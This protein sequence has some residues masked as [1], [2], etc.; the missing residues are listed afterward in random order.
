MEVPAGKREFLLAKIT[1]V[2]GEKVS[3]FLGG[4]TTISARCVLL[5]I[6]VKSSAAEIV[7]REVKRITFP[8]NISC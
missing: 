3:D 4:M 2:N 6:A 5:N 8:L 1:G 7:S